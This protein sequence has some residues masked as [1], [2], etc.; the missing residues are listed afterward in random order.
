MQIRKAPRAICQLFS[1]VPG[2]HRYLSTTMNVTSEW[3]LELMGHT[4][5]THGRPGGDHR[6]L[7]WAASN[8]Q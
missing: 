8:V 3:L 1:V 5:L 4:A 6:A 2:M 7:W